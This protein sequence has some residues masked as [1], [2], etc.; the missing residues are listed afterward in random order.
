[1]ELRD[2]RTDPVLPHEGDRLQ[3]QVELFLLAHEDRTESLPVLDGRCIATC[4]VGDGERV[5]DVGRQLDK[6]VG[7][8][9]LLRILVLVK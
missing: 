6:L 4:L 8:P 2:T 3:A 7:R 1:M 5:E 9:F